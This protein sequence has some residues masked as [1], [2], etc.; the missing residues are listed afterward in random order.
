MISKFLKVFFN[1]VSGVFRAR[2]YI[3]YHMIE[4]PGA[5]EIMWVKPVMASHKE[6]P[7]LDLGVEQ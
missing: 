2:S 5:I 7:V 4:C 1:E 3:F 6:K